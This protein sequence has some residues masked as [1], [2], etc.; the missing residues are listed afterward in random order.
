MKKVRKLALAI[1]VVSL[2]TV[3]SM[4]VNS[5]PY[6]PEETANIQVG[7]MSLAYATTSTPEIVIEHL[8]PAHEAV[9]SAFIW[10]DPENTVSDI[11][12]PPEQAMPILSL[13]DLDEYDTYYDLI[14]RKIVAEAGNQGY[15]GMRA[16]AQV[17][18]D[19]M[20][21]SET[22]WG[23]GF[24]GVLMKQ[25]QFAPTYT[26]NLSDFEP[27]VSEAMDAVFVHGDL[28]W[29]EVVVYFY[30]PATASASGK[31]FMETQKYVA[32]LGDHEFRME[33]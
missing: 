9:R 28:M 3:V 5:N 33:W 15:D 8:T 24:Y 29:D 17:I 12:V 11:P 32:T 25:G 10:D 1:S 21:R 26:G 20:Y 31:Q 6:P 13:T 22:D 19:R 2:I 23:D 30:N 16:V 18:Y 14:K 27:A 4:R 7:G